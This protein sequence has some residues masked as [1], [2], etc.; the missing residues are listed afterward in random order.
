MDNLESVAFEV[1][2]VTETVGG[3]AVVLFNDEFL[4]S[5]GNVGGDFQKLLKGLFVLAR[6]RLAVELD[7]VGVSEVVTVSVV[8]AHVDKVLVLSLL[9]SVSGEFD[10]LTYFGGAVGEG[11]LLRD[12]LVHALEVLV[13][14]ELSLGL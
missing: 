5:G 12:G 9:W 1:V 11:V 2:N 7:R 10:L 3:Q 6:H 4:Q 13:A 8:P 14:V